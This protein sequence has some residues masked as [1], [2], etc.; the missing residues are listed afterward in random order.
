MGLQ[1]HTHE[2]I[3]AMRCFVVCKRFARWVYLYTRMRKLQRCVAIVGFD[4]LSF[5]KD[6]QDGFTS[7]HA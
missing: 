4:A 2:V 7:T 1:I 6:L 3:T 5:V